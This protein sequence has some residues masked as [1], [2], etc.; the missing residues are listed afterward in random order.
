M[1]AGRASRDLE[2]Q[3]DRRPLRCRLWRCCRRARAPGGARP[4]ALRR[5]A[6]PSARQVRASPRPAQAV[7]SGL[8]R[9]T[10]GPPKAPC[11]LRQERVPPGFRMNSRDGPGRSRTCARGFRRLPA[12]V[13]FAAKIWSIRRPRASVRATHSVPDRDL[14]RWVERLHV[15]LGRTSTGG[16]R[17]VAARGKKRPPGHGPGSFRP[18]SGRPI[19][20]T[21]TGA[22]RSRLRRAASPTIN[23]ARALR[24][25]TGA[26]PPVRIALTKADH[27]RSYASP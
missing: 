21:S 4:S 2:L 18:H 16:P 10:G 15:R 26:G 7:S 13:L 27:W 8:E 1:S 12:E 20:S 19:S 22:P 5:F 11:N 25:S 6:C 23:A 9:T 14:V 3:G 17:R 24:P